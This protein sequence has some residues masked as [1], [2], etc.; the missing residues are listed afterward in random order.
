MKFSERYGHKPI[1]EVIQLESV[2][3][4]L[5]NTLWSVLKLTVWDNVKRSTGI[6]KGYYISDGQNSEIKHL[7][8]MLWFHYFKK[9]LDTLDDDWDEILEYLRRYFFSEAQWFEVLDFVEFVAN[10]Y[11]GYKFHERFIDRVNTALETEMSAYRFVGS[12]IAPITEESELAEIEEAAR[13]QESPIRTHLSRAIELMSD[14]KAPDYR[15]SIKESVSAVESL[16]RSATDNSSGTLGNLLKQLEQSFELH[17]AMKTA[18]SNLYGYSS[19]ES[20][21]RHALS[22]AKKVGFT[23]A[24]FMLVAC[25]AFINFVTAKLGIES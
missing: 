23:E 21:I 24:K 9:P 1:R 10:N 16:V 18:F 12:K 22:G 14:R 7:C 25:S 2:D 17:S 11:K 19:D 8:T 3:E 5:K 6:Y 4:T 13:H 15:N 20:G